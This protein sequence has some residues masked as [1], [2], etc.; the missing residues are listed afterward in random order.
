MARPSK[1][2]KIWR[3][4]AYE[5]FFTE[6]QENTANQLI[7]S[8]EEFETLRL[9][10]YLGMTQEEAARAM[11]V[12]RATVQML[13]AEARK[14]TA[15]FLV[16]G[17]ALRIEGGSYELAKA[18]DSG[19]FQKKGVLEMKI[20]VTYDNGQVF[21]HFGHTEEFKIYTVENGKV[22][23]SK[24]V[25][26]NGQGHG[27][28]AG[29][30]QEQGVDT[31]ICGGIGGGARNAL[32][33]AGIRLFPGA[34]GNADEQV[35]SFLKGQLSYDPDTSCNHHGEGHQC[36]GGRHGEGHQCGGEHHGKGHQ[37]GGGHHGEGH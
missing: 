29:F 25:G 10:D 27:A 4:P 24:V 9:L 22:E 36:G 31:L 35:A 13:S 37:C 17:T 30:L 6:G 23:D 33:E 16:E 15:R 32:A 7:L 18:G 28:L 8:V 5:R 20:A 14:K 21:Q 26:T 2:K 11:G 19:N 34:A 1:H 3:L 12:G